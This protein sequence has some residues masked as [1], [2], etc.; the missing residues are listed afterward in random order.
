MA[1][2]MIIDSLELL[3]EELLS[4]T[5]A[6]KY[7]PGNRSRPAL[8]RYVRKEVRGGIVLETVLI[9]GKRYTSREAIPFPVGNSVGF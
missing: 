7:F 2:K 3:D 8:E 5:A 4:L 6:C 1:S 9:C